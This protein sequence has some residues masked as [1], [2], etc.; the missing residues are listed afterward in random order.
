MRVASLVI[1]IDDSLSIQE[2]VSEIESNFPEYLP[3]YV[4]VPHPVS[5]C[6]TIHWRKII[7]SDNRNMNEVI[8]NI[9]NNVP[10]SRIIF[11]EW[12]TESGHAKKY[13]GYILAV[14][15]WGFSIWNIFFSK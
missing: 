2:T 13:I 4:V 8:A 10:S 14:A 1:L 6:K 9:Q 3:E 7:V 5:N 12:G 11:E 15:S